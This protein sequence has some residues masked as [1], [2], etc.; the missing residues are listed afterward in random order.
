M[1]GK[2]LTRC[3]LFFWPACLV[4]IFASNVSAQQTDIKQLEIYSGFTYFETPAFNL[5]ERGYHLQAGYNAR[6]WVGLGFDYSI[7]TGHNSLTT[8]LLTPAYQAQ[9][10]ALL[11]LLKEE[12]V[13]PPNYQLSVPTDNTTYTLAAG[14]QLVYRH[15]IPFTLFV[16]PSIGAIHETATPR[17]TDPVSTAIVMGLVPS[18]KKTDWTGFYGFGGGF[19]WNATSHFGLRAQ[20]DLVHNH[21]FSDLLEDGRW[22]TRLSIGPVFRFGRNIAAK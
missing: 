21:L 13:I 3:I 20:V 5:A 6:R 11:A 1:S 4:L 14:P 15:Y 16:R 10:D 19:D 7:V 2:M 12:G 8:N 22:T 18:G 17:P 9:I